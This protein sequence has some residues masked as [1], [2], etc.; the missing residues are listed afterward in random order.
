MESQ[1]PS[2]VR[3]HFFI[4]RELQGRYMLTFL[5]PMLILLA[6]MLFTLYMASQAIINTTTRII[7]R[8]IESK[9]ALEFQDQTSP[10]VKQYETFVGDLNQY[11]R[12]FLRTRSSSARW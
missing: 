3:K 12:E 9:I 5:I 10:T 1:K 6:F 11:I 7:Q 2:F 4:N 8:D